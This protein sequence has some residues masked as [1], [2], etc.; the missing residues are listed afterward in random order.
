M[1]DRCDRAGG[2]AGDGHPCPRE[3]PVPEALA[4]LPLLEYALAVTG[5]PGAVI[6]QTGCFAEPAESGGPFRPPRDL[7]ALRLRPDR[8]RAIVTERGRGERVL[9]LVSWAGEV[10]HRVRALSDTD[11]L[12]LD[13]LSRPSAR[14]P[15]A[16]ADPGPPRVTMPWNEADQLAQIDAVLSDGGLTRRRG[17]ASHYQG[18]VSAV[19]PGVLPVLLDHLCST[20]L[21]VGAAVFADAMAQ[22]AEGEVQL[23]SSSEQGRMG[24]VIGQST[25]DVDLTKVHELLLVRSHGPHGLTSALEIHDERGRMTA[26]LTQFGIVEAEVHAAWE[27]VAASLPVSSA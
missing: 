26:M 6:A 15:E 25:L 8:L 21:P 20:R 10:S 16:A 17:L 27:D 24:T 18:E 3:V 22:L 9:Q 23:V 11:H 7:I 1:D 5:S 19:E 14:R 4:V 2:C 13:G 12:V